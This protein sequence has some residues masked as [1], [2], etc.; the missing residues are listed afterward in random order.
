MAPV[1]VNDFFDTVVALEFLEHL[2]DPVAFLKKWQERAWRFIISIPTVK[3]VGR[4][5]YHKHDFQAYW[6]RQMFPED[7]WSLLNVYN[8]HNKSHPNIDPI[9]V[10]CVFDKL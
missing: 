1:E 4:N 9:C 10:C 5:I 3:S 6:P 2:D 8:Q 7:R